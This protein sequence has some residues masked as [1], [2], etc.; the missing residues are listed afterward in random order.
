MRFFCFFVLILLTSGFTG[1]EDLDPKLIELIDRIDQ[2]SNT[3]QTMR[4]HFK[5]RKEIS[6]LKEPVEMFGDFYLKRPD[7]IKFDFDPK[8]DL[9]L[10]LTAEEMVALSPKAKKANRVK[11]K[12]KNQLV[13]RLLSEKI[14][15]LSKYFT[16]EQVAE[17]ADGGVHL[18]LYP[19]KRRLKKR[20][21]EIHVWVN[22][23]FLINRVKVLSKDGD[24][25]E[26]ALEQIEINRELPA[27]LFDV[28]IPADYQMGDRIEHLLGPGVSF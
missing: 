6:L 1:K 14:K 19:S 20:F 5:Q 7:G 27:D 22:P 21:Q 11:M 26:L 2:K 13:Q 15:T 12:K 4:A 23:D 18:A 25:Y 17:E 16:V 8:E 3:I 24:L 28:E 9:I 10:I